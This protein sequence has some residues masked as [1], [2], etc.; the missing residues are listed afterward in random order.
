MHAWVLS[1]AWPFVTP[2]TEAHHAP[3]SIEFFRQEY[4]SGLPFPPAGNVLDPEIEPVS[5]VFP[6]LKVDSL[7]LRHLGGHCRG[8]RWGYYSLWQGGGSLQNT[9]RTG[10][11]RVSL[12]V[13][14]HL[15]CYSPWGCRV[16]RDWVTEQQKNAARKGWFHDLVGIQRGQTRASL[17]VWATGKAAACPPLRLAARGQFGWG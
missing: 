6:A 2:W 17:Q 11:S 13:R 9:W 16:R 8:M 3:L 1:H 4:W 10:G 12:G 15:A 14:C 5:P 7:P